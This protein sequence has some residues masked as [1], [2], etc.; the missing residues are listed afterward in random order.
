MSGEPPTRRDGVEYLFV[1]GPLDQARI[2]LVH[3]SSPGLMTV[4]PGPPDE[5]YLDVHGAPQPM[6]FDRGQIVT[7][8]DTYRRIDDHPDGPRF[9]HQEFFPDDE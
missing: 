3:R 7:A 9:V 6:W 4:S 1:G 5:V 2:V 8:T